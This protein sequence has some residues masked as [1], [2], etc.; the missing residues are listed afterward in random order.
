MYD[1]LLFTWIFPLPNSRHQK[2]DHLNLKLVSDKKLP[3]L[4][5]YTISYLYMY[6]EKQVYDATV[7]FKA[8][9]FG[10]FENVLQKATHIKSEDDN[11][12]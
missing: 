11:R 6:I 5:L 4:S 8:R 9:D 7:T 1:S 12:Q 3:S 2:T 10:A